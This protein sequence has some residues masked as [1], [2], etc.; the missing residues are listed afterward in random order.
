M[1]KRCIAMFIV[2]VVL[3]G[4]S[5]ETEEKNEGKETKV[6]EEAIGETEAQEVS[7]TNKD[8]EYQKQLEK[9][10]ESDMESFDEYFNQIQSSLQPIVTEI[11][12][13]GTLTE[14]DYPLLITNLESML[15]FL[16]N[17]EDY[18]QLEKYKNSYAYLKE[19][20]QYLNK[21]YIT[22]NS[23]FEEPKQDAS[24]FISIFFK[25]FEIYNLALEKYQ[26]GG[27]IYAQEY[28]GN[29]ID[30]SDTDNIIP[31]TMTRSEED[32]NRYWKGEQEIIN[33]QHW[34][35]LNEDEKFQLISLAIEQIESSG[36]VKTEKMRV[37]YV[38]LINDY[39]QEQTKINESIS[40]VLINLLL[41]EINP[42]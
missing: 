28:R 14:Q 31:I 29:E 5:A 41:E 11:S 35:K 18:S 36:I 25:G 34:I 6:A 20:N 38:N 17:M 7:T 9:D 21:A 10:F 23:F 16:N 1:M 32:G 3:M 2:C 24:T 27:K 37:D 30:T 12:R 39:F 22:F 19:G 33:G 26:Q 8:L 40:D 4:C 42:K 15:L 13:G